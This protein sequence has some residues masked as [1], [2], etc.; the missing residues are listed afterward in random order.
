MV[1]TIASSPPLSP[2]I[3]R[4]FYGPVWRIIFSKLLTSIQVIE[5]HYFSIAHH[6][7]LFRAAGTIGVMGTSSHN[8]KGN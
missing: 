6:A 1:A 5:R 7:P 8:F 3:Y 2:L 4:P